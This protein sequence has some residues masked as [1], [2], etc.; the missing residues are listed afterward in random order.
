MRV[1]VRVM[2]FPVSLFVAACALGAVSP[3]SAAP[4]SWTLSANAPALSWDEAY[5]VGNGRLGA[6]AYGN[7]SKSTIVLNESSIYSTVE[8]YRHPG[9]AEALRKARALCREGKF[10]EADELMRTGVIGIETASGSYRPA[11]FLRV[12]HPDQPAPAAIRRELDMSAGVT[13]ER[14]EFVSGKSK[15][16][17]RSELVAG[18]APYD[19]VAVRYTS[20]KPMRIAFALVTPDADAKRGDAPPTIFGTP[21]PGESLNRIHENELVY[22]GNAGGKGGTLYET[23]VRIVPGAGGKLTEEGGRLVVSGATEVV[24]YASTTTDF[25]LAKPSE[26]SPRVRSEINTA[27]LDEAAREGWSRVRESG[28]ARFRDAMN[29]CQVDIGDSAP[30]VLKLTT[31]ERLARV[32]S[33]GA[34]PDLYEQLFQFGRYCTVASSRPGALPPGLQGLWNPLMSPP[35][36]GSYTLNI[37]A[38]MN[39]WPSE[40]TGLGE[41]HKPFVDFVR[42][43]QPGGEAFAKQIGY[44]GLCIGHAVDIRRGTWFGRR[45][46]WW[47][48]GLMNGAWMGSHLVERYRFSGD[49]EDLRKSLPYLRESARF[50]MGWFERDDA[51]G[52]W[53]SGPGASPENTF[54]ADTPAGRKKVAVS[55]GCGYDQSLGRQALRDYVTACRELSATKDEL[56]ARAVERLAKTPPPPIGADG[57]VLEWRTDLPESEPDHRHVSHLLGL[58][59]CDDFNEH[60]TP[61]YVTA[62]RKSLDSRMA[63]GGGGTG[64]SAAW[65]ANLYAN[66]NDG[67]KA[68]ALLARILTKFTNPNLFNMHPPFQIDGNFG[69]TS[70]VAECLIRSRVEESGRRVVSLLPAVPSAWATGSAEGLRARGGLVVNLRWTP[71]GVTA[72]LTALRD[73]KFRVRYL[74]AHKDLDLTAGELVKVE[75]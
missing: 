58:F 53:I 62:V 60:D 68:H 61:A 42:G 29:R 65:M 51:T 20:E 34:D 7:F 33:G 15:Y 48:A 21:P 3:L 41:F 30:E 31:P 32:K 35:W 28:A 70:A 71:E 22:S 24:V 54:F 8:V 40:T 56:Y 19:V 66:T 52:E 57:R 2:R 10:F 49:K 6:I 18:A 23:R 46:T 38:E 55:L 75:F 39:Q 37:N 59:P 72:E 13:T 64:W 43:A 47:G 50:V 63:R 69:F 73:G 27:L 17:V 44:E 4:A 14:A 11:A 5:G 74:D 12:E 36:F 67:D 1:C 9:A 25:D 45:L 26:R 16:A